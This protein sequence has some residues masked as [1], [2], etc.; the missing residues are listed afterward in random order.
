MKA[1]RGLFFLYGAV[2]GL[3]G[4]REGGSCRSGLR[5]K[6]AAAAARVGD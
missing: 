6:A 3:D 1:V 4:L 2:R 5:Q